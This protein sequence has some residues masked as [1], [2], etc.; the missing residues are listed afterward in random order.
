[1][2]TFD[3]LVPYAGREARV[4]VRAEDAVL[5]LATLASAAAAQAPARPATPA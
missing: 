2:R 5:T 1:M 4:R 3:L